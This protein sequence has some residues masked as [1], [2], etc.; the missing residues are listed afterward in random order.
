MTLAAC[1]LVTRPSPTQI[2][3][4]MHDLHWK[5]DVTCLLWALSEIVAIIRNTRWWWNVN[6]LIC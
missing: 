5:T 6:S 4:L 2:M 1:D 3:H